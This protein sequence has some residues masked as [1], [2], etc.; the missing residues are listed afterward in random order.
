LDT[1]VSTARAS[2]RHLKNT[3]P[4]REKVYEWLRGA[5]LSGRF[6]PEERLTEEHLAEKMGVS[7]TPI[8]EA[9]H[10]LESEGLIKPLETRGFI[11]PPDS[12]EEVEELFDLRAVLEGYALR[13]I[14]ERTSGQNLER[15]SECLG[16]AEQA[17]EKKRI[18]DVFKWNTQFH[19]TLHGMVKE[20]ERLH[21]MMVEMREHV[22]RYRRDT[23]Q[24]PDAG[25]RTL[26]GHRKIL[27]ALRL[28][29][30]DLCERTMREHIQQAKED[31]LRTLYPDRKYPG[32]IG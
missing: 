3:V 26:D 12:R 28:K 29:D 25:T 22:L 7:R 19:D 13:V 18:N 6:N 16:R 24:H 23:L 17:L 30:P 27:L 14:C 4:V 15:L 1:I 32:E 20:R 10:K 21:R 5:I 2:T 31:A 9:L 11:V 8:R